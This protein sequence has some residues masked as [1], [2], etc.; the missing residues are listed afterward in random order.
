MAYFI[1]RFGGRWKGLLLVGLIAP[2]FIGYL[3]W[4]LAWINLLQDDGSVND[5]LVWIGIFDEPRNWLDGRRR[6]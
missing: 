3:I 1:A 5:V 6:R 4:M 2:F